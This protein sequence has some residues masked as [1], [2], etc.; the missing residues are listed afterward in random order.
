MVQSYVV[1]FL[2]Y[3]YIP[4]YYIFLST[5]FI[6]TGDRSN[7]VTKSISS[8]HVYATTL[9]VKDV[10]DTGYPMEYTTSLTLAEHKMQYQVKQTYNDVIT[11][12]FLCYY[13]SFF[14]NI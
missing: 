1:I 5:F 6:S 4:L 2:C 7:F 9:V 13:F 14:K 11:K 3:V 8:G 10:P 12:P